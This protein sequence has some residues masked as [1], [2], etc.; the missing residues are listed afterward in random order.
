MN[1]HLHEQETVRISDTHTH[2]PESSLD[3]THTHA[4][5]SSYRSN[6]HSTHLAHGERPFQLKIMWLRVRARGADWRMALECCACTCAL[7]SQ[8]E[9]T[10]VFTWTF[11]A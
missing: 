10:G 2:A 4:P 9:H 3:R 8:P 7:W 6:T 11:S 1:Q 5:E